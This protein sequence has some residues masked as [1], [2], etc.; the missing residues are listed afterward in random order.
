MRSDEIKAIFDQ[1]ASSY[2]ERWAKTA[3]IRDALLYLLAAVFAELPADARILCIGV[4]TGE[5]IDNLAKKFPRWTFT[6]VEPSGAMLDV[7]RDK[8][9]KGGFVSRCYF[10]EGYLESLPMQDAFD[11]ATC[12]LVSQFILEREARTDFFRAIA[13]RLRPG[14]ILASS[15]LASDVRSSEYAALLKSWLNMML[16][17]GIP[18]AGLEQ[19]S[20]AY[21][22]DVAILPPAQVA[23]LIKSGGFDSAVMFYQ[24]GLIHAWFSTRASE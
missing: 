6:A 15:D 7:C 5:E 2:D 18:A 20:A 19:M 11:A 21:A 23:S 8:A 9:E 12:F 1:Q 4:G 3:P 24:A 16:G 17:A 10:H 22:R 13:L 14:G